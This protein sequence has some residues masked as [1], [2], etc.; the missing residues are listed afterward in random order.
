M[1]VEE[2]TT[3]VRITLRDVYDGQQQMN[4]TLALLAERLPA[5]V[6]KTDA[7]ITRVEQV[8]VDHEKRLRSIETRLWLAVG[9]LTLLVVGADLIKPL[10]S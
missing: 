4:T 5:H 10:I 6:E 8:Q 9:G 7:A 2:T 3:V 1:S